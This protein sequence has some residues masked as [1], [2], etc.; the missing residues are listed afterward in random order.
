M[1]SLLLIYIA[2]RK[3]G[4]LP[5]SISEIAY[6]LPSWIFTAWMA[7]VGMAAVYFMLCECSKEI[8]PLAFLTATGLFMVAASPYYKVEAGGVHNVG[9]WMAAIF[10]QIF[11]AIDCPY[12]LFGWLAFIPFI[13]SEKRT[14]FAEVICGLILLLSLVI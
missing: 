12:L 14:F 10:S 1:I 6:I 7:I 4:S 8:E 2:T 3:K 5:V 9:G 13:K 11:V